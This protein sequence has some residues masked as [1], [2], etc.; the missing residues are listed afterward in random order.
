MQSAIHLIIAL[1]VFLSPLKTYAADNFGLAMHGEPKYGPNDTHLEYANPLAPKGGSLKIASIGSFDSINPYSIK[2][3]PAEGLSLVYDKLMQRVW[4]EPFTL[5]PLIAESFQAAPD[6]SWIEFKINPKAKFQDGSPITADDVLYSFTTLKDNGRPNMRRIYKLV[7]R[8]EKTGPLSIKFSFGEGYDRESIMIIAMIPILSKSWGEKNGFETDITKTPL[9]NGPYKIK[10][11]DA[12]KK[13][14]YE[15]DPNYWGADLLVNAGHYNFDTITYEYFRDDTIA[16]EALRKGDLDL[17]RELDIRKWENNYT[18]IN[19]AVFKRLEIPH[20]RPERTMAMIFNMRRPPFN[21][22]K[23]RKAL[24]LAFDQDWISKNIYFNKL[25][26]INSYYPNSPLDGSSP[27]SDAVKNILSPWKDLL[28]PEALNGTISVSDSRSER[29]RLREASQL[30]KQAGWGI[31]NGK[32]T[33]IKSGQPFEFE[34]ILSSAA[35]EKIALTYQRALE[36][37]GIGMKI[38]VLDSAAFQNKKIKYDYDMMLFFWQN[39]LSPGTEQALY[40]SCQSVNAESQLNF[41]GICNPAL[42]TL[43]KRISDAKTYDDLTA[44]AQAIDRILLTQNISIPLFYKGSDY[45]AMKTD[46]HMPSI[47]PIYGFI[48]ETLWRAEQK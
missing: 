22:I 47:T 8:A 28:P 43:I 19:P 42:D 33:N 25:S 7:Q 1:L 6:R 39:S 21:D 27:P 2:G 16:L 9:L 15:R 34:L 29:E 31:L 14:V 30:L 17:R 35:E 10:T 48:M 5:Y 18:Q 37:L 26:R 44:A 4:D 24:S 38:R 13:I 12:G 46:I 3:V 32:L 11:V 41:S 36:R 23:I 40:W 20:Q 45:V